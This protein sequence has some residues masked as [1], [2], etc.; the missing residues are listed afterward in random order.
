MPD[1]RD[2]ARAVRHVVE[3]LQAWP[4]GRRR[5]SP[6]LSVLAPSADDEEQQAEDREHA[7]AVRPVG[8]PR[9]RIASSATAIR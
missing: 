6:R 5:R 2:H 7:P 4:A 1:E 9:K 8:S 3:R